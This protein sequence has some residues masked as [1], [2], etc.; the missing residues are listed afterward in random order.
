MRPIFWRSNLSVDNH[1]CGC[2]ALSSALD[3][4]RAIHPHYL[5]PPSHSSPWPSHFLSIPI[6][7]Y[8]HATGSLLDVARP[9]LCI[10]SPTDSV[11]HIGTCTASFCSHQSIPFTFFYY[12]SFASNPRLFSHHLE[13]S[14]ITYPWRSCAS[15]GFPTPSSLPPQLGPC[16]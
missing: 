1:L 9:Y 4:L 5:Q 13:W 6:H 15:F 10:T 11:P 16:Q 7:R 12:S 2:V 3:H 14:G 8:L